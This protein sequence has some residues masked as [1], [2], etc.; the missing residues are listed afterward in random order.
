[1]LKT[2]NQQKFLDFR[3]GFPVFVFEGFDFR[4]TTEE[5]AVQFHFSLSGEYKFNPV[6]RIPDRSFYKRDIPPDQLENIFFQI[7]LVEMI[8]YWKTACPSRI[9]IKNYSLSDDQKK[10]WRKLFY[11]GLGEFLFLNGI[12]IE[13]DELLTFECGTKELEPFRLATDESCIIPVG[14]GKDSA[15]SMELL[16]RGSGNL[17]F[18]VNPGKASEDTIIKSGH[19]AEQSIVVYRS[20]DP[21]LPE[22][23]QKGFLNGHTPF[24]ALLAFISSL[25][26][27]LAGKKYIV[28]SNESS[29]NES[30]IPGTRINHQYS[31][32]IEFERD[33]RDY[34][35]E[36]VTS[37]IRYFSF[38]RPLGELRIAELFSRFPHHFDTF[39]SCNAGSKT[40]SWCGKCSKCL[41]TWI[42]LSPFISPEILEKI[43]GKNLP[44]DI[45]LIPTL[46][47]L[48][49]IAD[50]KPFDCVGTIDEVNI[51]LVRTIG[52]Y[53][54]EK[55][56]ALLEHYRKSRKYNSFRSASFESRLHA[57]DT[58]H[59]LP[60][61]F[62]KILKSW[63]ND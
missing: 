10:W 58:D 25:T 44:E 4:R 13:E 28:L 11:H 9:I 49:G 26:A 48:T 59:Y 5:L 36:Y 56:P 52:Q 45:E 27:V 29:A 37:D 38:L 24:S 35:A 50:E 43:F 2:N 32:S 16:G 46:E 17:P 31:K 12:R 34:L 39:R 57:Y 18:T 61:R 21:L 63:L 19:S 22:L 1:M 60:E 42:I 20:I 23:N 41:F 33:F 6:I 30:T 14:G 15:V 40:N 8:S 54:P 62:E 3:S 55:L 51:A 47:E 7:G 53:P